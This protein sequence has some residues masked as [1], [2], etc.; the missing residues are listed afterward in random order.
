LSK[1]RTIVVGGG[2]AGIFAALALQHY[3]I[4]VALVAPSSAHDPR[5][6]ALMNPAIIA[7]KKLGVYEALA[8]FFTPLKAMRLIDMTGSLFKSPEITFDSHELSL[9]AFGYNIEN[10]QLTRILKAHFKGD[11]YAYRVVNYEPHALMLDDKTVLHAEY[12][13]AADGRNSFIRKAAGITTREKT[14]PQMAF[15]CSFTHK[16]PHHNTSTEFHTVEGP[17]TFVPMEGNQSSLVWV[18]KPS[19]A[20]SLKTKDLA[21][22]ISKASNHYLGKITLN[23]TRGFFPLTSITASKLTG[24]GLALIGEAA[25]VLPPIG[26]QGLNLGF[27]D[28]AFFAQILTNSD[29]VLRDY[30]ASRILDIESRTLAV[31]SLN[32]SLISSFGFVHSG[33]A[34]GMTMIEKI[35]ALRGFVMKQGLA[36]SNLPELM[37]G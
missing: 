8:P 32:N 11:V 3:N 33:R 17:M 35:P 31:N 5:T 2:A 7:L 36:P 24:E 20:E 12:I 1:Y 18:M 15:T 6:T 10:H 30:E 19:S 4:E 21:L 13:L 27:R 29:N 25:H 28:G 23:D 22:E 14:L 34:I 16:N 9:E 26:A 37:Q